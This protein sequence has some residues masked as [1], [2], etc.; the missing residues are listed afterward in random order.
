ML[1]VP[2]VGM[3]ADAARPRCARHQS[4]GVCGGDSIV[5]RNCPVSLRQRSTVPW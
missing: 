1:Q 5:G 4:R 2:G 3:I